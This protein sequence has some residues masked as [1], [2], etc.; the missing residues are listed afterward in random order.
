[1]KKSLKF[2]WILIK[3]LAVGSAPYLDDHIDF[4]KDIGI[5]GVLSLCD[6]NEI[7][8]SELLEKNFQHLS[9]PI[10]DHTCKRDLTIVEVF[11]ALKG[12]EGTPM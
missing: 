5:T 8:L 6:Q 11:E 2:N 9:F 7:E 12:N 1:M 10:P 3:E 4:L